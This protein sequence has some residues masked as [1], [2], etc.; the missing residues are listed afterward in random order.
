MQAACKMGCNAAQCAHSRPKK[1]QQPSICMMCAS[2]W[3]QR[4][5]NRLGK[6][7]ETQSRKHH[8]PPP[9]QCAIMT[10]WKAGPLHSFSKDNVPII[11]LETSRRLPRDK[12]LACPWQFHLSV[13]STESSLFRQQST[14]GMAPPS[15]P[16]TK[17][18][19]TETCQ[20]PA[21]RVNPSGTQHLLAAL[22]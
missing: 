12:P 3:S 10:L 19:G 21:I 15:R 7:G 22:T 4:P 2:D 20:V 13:S 16:F 8:C 11:L 1:G 18:P 5:H 14:S 17:P 9:S 6:Q